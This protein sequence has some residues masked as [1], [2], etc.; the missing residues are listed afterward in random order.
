MKNNWST[1]NTKLISWTASFPIEAKEDTKRIWEFA[2]FLLEKGAELEIYEVW[3]TI[4]NPGFS[5]ERDGSYIDFCK[6]ISEQHGIISIFP[7]PGASKTHWGMNCTPSKIAYYSAVGGLIFEK[8]CNLGELQRHLLLANVEKSDVRPKPEIA[9]VS[10]ETMV[11][12]NMREME[13]GN[14][15]EWPFEIQIGLYTDIWFPKVMS[16]ADDLLNE[17]NYFASNPLALHHTPRFNQFLSFLRSKT[18]SLGGE[19]FLDEVTGIGKNY[20]SF[21][22]EEGIIL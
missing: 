2:E 15:P 10:V 16:Y 7:G 20:E 14:L 11:H 12:L 6:A 17:E 9:P 21:V 22:N 3:E 5:K 4:G 8:V 1:Y 18:N 19:W 13:S